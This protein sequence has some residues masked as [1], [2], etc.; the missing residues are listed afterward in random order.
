[1][2][3]DLQLAVHGSKAGS[4]SAV[5]VQQGDVKDSVCSAWHYR[6]LYNLLPYAGGFQFAAFDAEQ[7]FFIW[8]G[9]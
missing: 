2:T 8:A 1:M 3:W 9:K 5:C 6:P 7:P 4:T